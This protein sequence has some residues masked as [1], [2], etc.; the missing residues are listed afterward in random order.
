[1]NIEYITFSG[2]QFLRKCLDLYIAICDIFS[3]LL[4]Y[5]FNKNKVYSVMIEKILLKISWNR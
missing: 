3:S 2:T 5:R 1:M 4:Q